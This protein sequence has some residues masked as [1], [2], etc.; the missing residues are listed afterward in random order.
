MKS[1]LRSSKRSRDNSK[2]VSIID[3]DGVRAQFGD[4]WGLVRASN[5]QPALVLRFE[6][7]TERRLYEIKA[8]LK[9]RFKVPWRAF[10]SRDRV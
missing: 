6:A 9:R 7:L 4:G 10:E 3:V 5:T 1:N 2:R 8:W